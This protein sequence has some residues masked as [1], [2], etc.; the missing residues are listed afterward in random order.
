MVSVS[1]ST[2]NSLVGIAEL[3]PSVSEESRSEFASA[4]PRNR[5]CSSQSIMSIVIDSTMYENSFAL[6]GEGRSFVIG[7]VS[8]TR[9]LIPATL[10]HHELSPHSCGSTHNN[11]R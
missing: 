5:W 11:V 6:T 7:A 4:T 3:V 10:G 1:I 2:P 9:N 8:P